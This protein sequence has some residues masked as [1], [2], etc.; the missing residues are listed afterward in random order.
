[1]KGGDN[2]WVGARN[3]EETVAQV[4]G[5][6]LKQQDLLYARLPV[7][8]RRLLEAKDIICRGLEK[9]SSPYVSFSGGKDSEVVLH[10]VLQEKPDIKVI[11]INQGAEYP[12]TRAFIEKVKSEWNI[13]LIE[14]NGPDVLD[15]MEEYGAFGVKAKSEYKPGNIGWRAFYQPLFKVLDELEL[16]ATFMGLRKEENLHR[17]YSLAK[18]GNITWCKYDETWHIN[19]IANWKVEDVWAYITTNN[20]P[21]NS[22]YDKNKFRER[23]A[24]RVSPFAGD[25]YATYGKFIELKYYHPD[26]FAEFARRFPGIK[27]YI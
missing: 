14:T 8:K 1:M 10:L 3:Q 18:R 24:I 23:N 12:E 9:C 17:L 22:I 16:D 26:I 2:E 6:E 27:G 19:P 7:F 20:L 13:D 21:Y 4:V 25:T 5:P 15:L 11:H